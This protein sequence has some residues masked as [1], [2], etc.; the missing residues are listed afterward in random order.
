MKTS[1]ASTFPKPGKKGEFAQQ[2]VLLYEIEVRPNYLHDLMRAPREIQK[3]VDRA[4]QE[5]KFTPATPHGAVIKKL[6]GFESLWR[7]RLG[8]YRLI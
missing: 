4:Q 6:K 2:A 7:Y 1:K 3:K 5:L 8:D